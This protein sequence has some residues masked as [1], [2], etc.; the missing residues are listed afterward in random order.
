MTARL[1]IIAALGCLAAAC[2][3]TAPAPTPRP[4]GYQRVEIYPA[5]YR[6]EPLPFGG[7]SIAV[8]ASAIMEPGEKSGW[9]NIVYPAYGITVNCTMIENLG[10]LLAAPLANRMER[11]LLN[12]GTARAEIR[13][14]AGVTMVVSPRSLRT[15]VQ[16]LATD[17]AS[18]MLMGVAVADFPA[19]TDADSIAPVVD[20]VI[21]DID[22]MLRSL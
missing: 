13:Q 5:L 17:S 14:W 6:K 8:N 19:E 11:M 7:D 12:V 22:V 9:F 10:G 18:W 15:P 2:S 21:T 1:L 20:A 16:F 3:R 4:Y